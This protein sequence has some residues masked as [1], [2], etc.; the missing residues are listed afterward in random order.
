MHEAIVWRVAFHPEF[1]E[2]FKG[3][4]RPVQ[5]ALARQLRLLEASGP[6]LGRPIVDSLKGSVIA[7]LKELRFAVDGGIWRVAFAFDGH[8]VAI[9]LASGNKAG[10]SQDRFY[11]TL[12]AKAEERWSTWT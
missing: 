3:F 6:T 10:V 4:A 2:E 1:D 11:R 12:I 8:R 7:N 5:T 9:L